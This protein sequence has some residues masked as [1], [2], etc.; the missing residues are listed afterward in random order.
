MTL[1]LTKLYL[2]EYLIV[3]IEQKV[4]TYFPLPLEIFCCQSSI[5][6]VLLPPFFKYAGYLISAATV[7][8]S[9][10][11]TLTN[12]RQTILLFPLI[13]Q[14]RWQFDME[15]FDYSEENMFFEKPKK[16]LKETI[17]VFSLICSRNQLNIHRKGGGMLQ[18][19][20][21]GFHR[22]GGGRL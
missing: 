17:R 11:R 14:I 8:L 20:F 19:I 1:H 2:T 4:I 13:T 21:G 5:S 22:K 12:H 3:K 16:R 9:Y 10:V 7:N 15:S 18:G 6:L